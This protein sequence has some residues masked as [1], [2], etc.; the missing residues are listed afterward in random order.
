MSGRAWRYASATV[1]GTSHAR[2]GQPCQDAAICQVLLMADGSTLFVA[3]AADGAGSASRGG[4]GAALA[5]DLFVDEAEA[6]VDCGQSVSDF[7][8]TVAKRWIDRF[9]QEV[10]ARAAVE[11]VTARDYACTVLATVVGTEGAAFFQIGDGAIVYSLR[12]EADSYYCAFWP[13][14]GEYANMTRF[15]TDLAACEDFDFVNVDWRVDDVALFTDGIERLALEFASRTAF[16]PFFRAMFAPIRA[17]AP[18]SE[19]ELSASLSNYL[20]SGSINERTDDDKSL[21]LASRRMNDSIHAAPDEP[22]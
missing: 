17:A 4:L 7:S 13:A 11:G 16:A 14:K 6:L 9:Q 3:V 12:D 19:A 15:A 21:I 10:S 8:E 20:S 18:G 2:T 1:V 22:L 5:C